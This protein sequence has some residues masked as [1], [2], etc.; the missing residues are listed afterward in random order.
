MLS[1]V[2]IQ[3]IIDRLYFSVDGYSLSFADRT[4]PL[5]TDKSFIYGEMLLESLS[6]VMD[7][8]SPQPGELFYDLG[9]GTGK[10]VMMAHLLYPFARAEGVE[11]LP[12][13][14]AQALTVHAR[15]DH[16]IRPALAEPRGEILFR[17]GDILEQDLS[18]ADVIFIHGTCFQE[19]FVNKLVDKMQACKAGAR[20]VAPSGLFYVPWLERKHEIE[21][22]TAWDTAATCYTYYKV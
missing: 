22:A 3:T 2:E 17:H 5:E 11:L 7:P 10:L 20:I 1:H 18:V 15:Y 21:Y 6:R 12:S 16:E 19:A 4:G 9:S 14:H 8:V 13:L